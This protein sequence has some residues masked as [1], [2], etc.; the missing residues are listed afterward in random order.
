[1]PAVSSFIALHVKAL[2]KTYVSRRFITPL[3]TKNA[4]P[5]S[6]KSGAHKYDD[7]LLKLKRPN[8]NLV[9]IQY[10]SHLT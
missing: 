1:M 4:F 3:L 5:P 10:Y 2:I 7:A 8:F 9:I 6:Q